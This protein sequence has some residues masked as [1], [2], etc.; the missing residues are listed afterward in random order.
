MTKSG[1]GLIQVDRSGD[2]RGDAGDLGGGNDDRR[3]LVM[4][5]AALMMAAQVLRCGDAAGGGREGGDEVFGCCR[6]ERK[7]VSE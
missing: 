7:C 4:T 3:W 5:D 6:W 1:A 2:P